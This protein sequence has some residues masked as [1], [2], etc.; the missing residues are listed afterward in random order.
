ELLG[1]PANKFIEDR[2]FFQK[3][4]HPGDAKLVAEK[5]KEWHIAGNQGILNTEFRVRRADGTY[6]WLEDHMITIKNAA[7]TE[8]MAGVLI[9]VNEHKKAEEKLKQLAEKLSISNQDL[10][11]FAYV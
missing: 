5:V 9:D 6:I 4:M 2:R 7:G 11:Q 8:H 3:I 1:Y 10:E